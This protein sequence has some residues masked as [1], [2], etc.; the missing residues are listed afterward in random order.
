MRYTE[1]KSSSR[2]EDWET[3][4]DLF[5]YLDRLFDFEVD[6]AATEENKKC[7]RFVG[8]HWDFLSMGHEAIRERCWCNP[9]YGRAHNAKWAQA[10][11]K[12]QNV[13]VLHQ[14][15]VGAAWFRPFWEHA[16]YL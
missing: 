13:V 2:R 16:D 10:L 14:A 9:P 12:I 4:P 3:P 15:S 8:P 11:M 7:D 6:L 1:N 5:N